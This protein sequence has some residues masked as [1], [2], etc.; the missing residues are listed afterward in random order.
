MEKEGRDQDETGKLHVWQLLR[1][2]QCTLLLAGSR[3]S[4]G[5]SHPGIRCWG[6]AFV[7][8]TTASSTSA[9]AT[10][11]LFCKEASLF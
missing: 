4:I 8:G 6:V 5:P 11:F 1:G 3:Q 10:A 9:E 2:G 7:F